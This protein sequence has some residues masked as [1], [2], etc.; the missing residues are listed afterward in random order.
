[1][2]SDL[3]QAIGKVP[4]LTGQSNYREWQ[5]EVK[6]TARLA[7]VWKAITGTDKPVVA[8]EAADVAAFEAREEKAIG[9]ITRTVSSHLKLELDEY[10]VKDSQNADQEAN[11]K[12]MWAYLQT[13]FEKKDGI[14]AII[15][16]GRLTRAKLVDD[17]TLEEQ[18]NALQELRSRC[19]LND[20]KYADWQ[21]AALILLALPDSFDNI[22]DHFLTTSTPKNLKPDDIRAR[23]LE[24]QNRKKDEADVSAANLITAKSK[25]NAKGKQKK[26]QLTNDRSSCLNCG[27]KGHWARECCSKKKDTPSSSNA[28]PDKP[29]GSS[30]NVVE[31]SD[32]E[33]D[34]P[35]LCYFGAPENWLM[36]SGATDHMTPFGSDF[37]SVSY[38]KF[39]ESRTVVLGDGSTRLKIIGKGTVERWV[40][41]A[42]HV[43]RQLILQD[44]LHVDGIKRRFLSMG[45]FDDK[46]FSIVLSNSRLKISKKN[47]A[48]SGT[49]AGP[50]YTCILYADKPLGAHSLNS[51]EALPIKVWHDRMGHLNWD[52]IKLIR[53]DNPPLIGIKL[54]ASDPP[55]E[56]CH[57]CV[58]GKAK[59]RMFKSAGSRRTRST[60][61]IERIHAD[62]AGP[63]EVDSIGG[64]RYICVFTCDST[65]YAWV[66]LLKS[67]DKTLHTFKRFVKMIET[68]TG[69]KIKFFRSDRGGEFMS[70]EFTEFLEEQGI[71]RET[72]APGTPQQNGVAERMNQTL[73]GGARALLHHSG[74]SKGFWAEAMGVAAHV[75]NRAPRKGLRWRTPHEL[76][77]GRVPDVSYIR[78]F[79][80][81]AWVFNDKGKK[82]D[83]KSTPM[84]F[85]GYEPGA[86]AFRLWNPATRSIVVSAN[87]RFSEREFPSRPVALP[88]PSPAPPIASSSET[89]IPPA[90]VVELPISFFDE[91]P[92]PHPTPLP[93]PPPVKTPVPQITITPPS[94]STSAQPPPPSPPPS[95]SLDSES[96][97]STPPAPRKSTRKRKPVNKFVGSAETEGDLEAFDQAYLESVELYTSANSSNEPR[98]YQ[99]AIDSPDSDKWRDAMADELNSLE[100]HGTWEIVDRPQGRRVISSKWVYRVKYDADG[101]VSRHK[102]RL[103]ARGFTQVHGVDYTDTFAP[104]TRLET[105]RLLFAMAVEKDWEVRQ[106]DVKT[107]YLYGD[108]DEEVYM[109]PPE[110]TD[111]GGKVYRLLKAIY[112][113][114]Q[115][116]R[117]WY[118]KLKETMSEFGLTQ[119]ISEPHTFVAHKVVEGVKL[120]IILPIY[121]DDLFPVGNKRLTDEFEAWI[122]NYFEITAPCDAHYFLGIRIRRNRNP[123]DGSAPYISLD[124]DKYIESVLGRV[125]EPIK[126]YETPLPTAE[127]VPNPEPKESADPE[128]VHQYQSA[129][130]QLMYIMLGTRPDLAFAVGK[131]SRFSSN[132]SPDHVRAVQ[133]TFGYLANYN[134]TSLV[135]RRDL[136]DPPQPIFGYTDADWA[137][138]TSTGKSTTGYV[139]FL[140]GAAFSWSSKKQEV[141]AGSTMEAEYVALYHTGRQAAWINNFLEQIGFPLDGPLEVKCDNEAAIAVAN[142]GELPFK[143]SKH[144][145]VK[146][147][148]IRD[149]VNTNQLSVTKVASKENLADQFTKVLSR[150][151]FEEQSNA[152][153]FEESDELS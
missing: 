135:Y 148:T 16:Y 127:L 100:S 12:E 123:E 128:V 102:A 109:E 79:G 40:E 142:G 101:N 31:T 26:K 43:Y 71:T 110:G 153:G 80:C 78:V 96:E 125:T 108:L 116:G 35:V 85:V 29:G 87:V 39:V 32:A 149:Y 59:R 66:Y 25:A 17:G 52:S 9:L 84:I 81:R 33:S 141:T 99:E 3:A 144:I 28:G 103:V 107:A 74:M 152:L 2:S 89:H 151:A 24:K 23:I 48:F 64:H 90:E 77:Y 94:P 60:Y 91:V 130:G 117:Q 44:V 53:S 129:I 111:L 11:S 124:Q 104:V 73:I 122:P 4:V 65:S 36:D 105:L 41:T 37:T 46:G 133:R 57:G 139:F 82:W 98:T 93:P 86:K 1:M 20:F 67:K 69:N 76:L 68:L 150:D 143:K 30:L 146:Y 70:G 15:D 83:P 45:R 14:S 95:S 113:L 140:S 51:V 21:F 112:G 22:K 97:P 58:A 38:V 55:H 27:R 136:N 92:K 62:L 106:I 50:L 75:I 34:S 120:T 147:H 56:T 63:M 126:E 13:K 137:G 5:I 121:V 88:P 115:A 42:P 10:R 145:N 8:T 18:L 61:P 49:K 118:R 6:A 19:A 138:D 54:D 114:K 47:F 72:T 7:N 131:L 134:N 132:P 119:V